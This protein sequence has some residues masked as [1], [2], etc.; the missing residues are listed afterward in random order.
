MGHDLVGRQRR[1]GRWC[2]KYDQSI[3]LMTGGLQDPFG[4]CSSH[5]VELSRRIRA[6]DSISCHAILSLVEASVL[7]NGILKGL[8]YLQSSQPAA[9][10]DEPS[11]S[12][13]VHE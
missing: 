4:S 5:V 1:A 2:A 11:L 6:T 8:I 7:Q 13:S 10:L 12:E 9:V 3:F